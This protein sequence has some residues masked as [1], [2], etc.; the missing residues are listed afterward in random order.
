MNIA[1]PLPLVVVVGS[2]A[3]GKTALGIELSRRFNGEVI[4]ADSRAIYRG[5]NIGTAKPTTAEMGGVPHW[6]IDLVDPNDSFTAADFQKYAQQK[7]REIRQRGHL[8]IMVGGS[9][10][11]VDAVIFNYDFY[12]PTN[13]T[14]KY[15]IRE[16]LANKSIMELQQIIIEHKISMPKN[17]KNARYL[18]R[19]I[20]RFYVNNDVVSTSNNRYKIQPNIIIVGIS[21]D[22]IIV[23][24]RIR[25]RIGEMFK[26]PNLADETRN[27]FDQYAANFA[28]KVEQRSWSKTDFAALPEALKSNLYLYKL[29]E[30]NGELTC[31]E[32]ERLAAIKD[33]HLAKR[34]MTWFRRNKAITWLL[35]DQIPDFLQQQLSIK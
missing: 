1:Q 23:R 12:R 4:S 33:W 14:Q 9:G 31:S 24:Q 5:L 27:A 15:Q 10:L 34:Q 3:A 32:A 21:F 26:N 30:M 17:F 16:Q 29:R 18:I 25:Q 8:P 20:E 7:I 2:T 35:S 11:Y 22:K 19:A 13:D 6:G 28:Q